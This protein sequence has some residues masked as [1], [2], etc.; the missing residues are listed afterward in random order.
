[1]ESGSL[2]LTIAQLA[3]AFAGFSAIIV[4]LNN[5]PVRDWDATDRLN[6]RCLLQV[7][8]FVIAFS[9]FP[10]LLAISLTKAGVWK[11]G[12]WVYGSLIVADA[13][14]FYAI[15]TKDSPRLF[16]N[17][18]VGGIVIGVLQ[19]A[20]AAVGTT[21]SRESMYVIALFWQ[22][23]IVVMS[24]LLLLYQVRKRA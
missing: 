10:F 15:M 6:L 1:M 7:S 12:T 9:L 22:F 20:A 2:L 17:A 23:G 21:A 24:F 16:R 11:V 8:V 4:A 3:V 14:F 18:A 19:I 13:S 5:R